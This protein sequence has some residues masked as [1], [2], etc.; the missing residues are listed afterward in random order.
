MKL[1]PL[2]RQSGRKNLRAA[3]TI[4]K[5][6]LNT[7]ASKSPATETTTG[8]ISMDEPSSS[9]SLTGISDIDSFVENH[10]NPA[11]SFSPL[12]TADTSSSNTVAASSSKATPENNAATAKGK[13]L[14]ATTTAATK[15]TQGLAFRPKKPSPTLNGSPIKKSRALSTGATNSKKKSPTRSPALDLSANG[16]LRQFINLPGYNPEGLNNAPYQP[17]AHE[18]TTH[19]FAASNLL[20]SDDPLDWDCPVDL[21]NLDVDAN[22]HIVCKDPFLA[23]TPS[24]YSSIK[25]HMR[26][27]N[28][29]P[30]V[31]KGPNWFRFVSKCQQP[32]HYIHT[33]THTNVDQ[34]HELADEYI[35]SLVDG[36]E[37]MEMLHEEIDLEY[38]VSFNFL[39]PFPFR[40]PQTKQDAQKILNI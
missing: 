33:K 37:E 20:I 7:I 8:S 1:N 6:F 23:Q 16:H 32:V 10:S 19:D 24:N 4:T 13:G 12:S 17:L 36:L 14:F 21:A 26:W 34:Y 25:T 39:F 11:A 38:S 15:A 3:H 22:G 29:D 31:F 18:R 35:E 30:G 2:A 5:S 9:S 40:R 28:A 27:L